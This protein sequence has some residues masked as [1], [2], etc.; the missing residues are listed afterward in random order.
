MSLFGSDIITVASS[1]EIS[2]DVKV[3]K[4]LLSVDAWRAAIVKYTPDIAN[5]ARDFWMT[6]AGQRL[7]TSRREYQDAIILE[8]V[9]DDTFKLSLLGSTLASMVELGTSS[10]DMK[11]GFSGKIIPLNVDRQVVF[12]QPKIFRRGS[13]DG[14]IHPGFEAANIHEDVIEEIAENI[15]PKYAQMI[16]EGL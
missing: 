16:V 6:A 5:E 9:N 4:D 8:Y 3:P 7:K 10:F 1:M 11:P 13:S 14:W 15:I 2:L 12:T